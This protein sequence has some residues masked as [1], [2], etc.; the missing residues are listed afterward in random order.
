MRQIKELRSETDE[1]LRMVQEAIERGLSPPKHPSLHYEQL[2]LAI[3]DLYEV[4]KNGNVQKLA[5]IEAL[6][7]E[8]WQTTELLSFNLADD[9]AKLLGIRVKWTAHVFCK[10]FSSCAFFSLMLNFM[11]C[12]T[13]VSNSSDQLG[14]VCE[15]WGGTVSGCG[16]R[17]VFAS[18]GV[19]QF[20]CQKCSELLRNVAIHRRSRY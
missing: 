11:D 19:S 3:A 6:A 9:P 7:A 1:E 15:I 20:G 10:I 18:V 17:C 2:L 5:L 14:Q 4:P 8:F 13:T 16:T 12:L